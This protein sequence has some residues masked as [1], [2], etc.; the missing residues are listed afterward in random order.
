MN[1]ERMRTCRRLEGY[2][3]RAAPGQ[4]SPRTR[5]TSTDLGRL[6][7]RSGWIRSLCGEVDNRGDTFSVRLQGRIRSPCE[8]LRRI[9]QDL[10]SDPDGFEADVKILK[11]ERLRSV[12]DAV[13][14][15]KVPASDLDGF[16]TE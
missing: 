14:E 3:Q 6:L 15:F 2:V 12:C 10:W 13:E 16:G 1:L 11:S 7:E 9:N 8:R 4:N 5:A